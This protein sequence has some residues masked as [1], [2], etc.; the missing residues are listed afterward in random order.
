[1]AEIGVMPV[2][3]DRK[4]LPAT[5]AAA[6]DTVGM[7]AYSKLGTAA[8]AREQVQVLE[9]VPGQVPGQVLEQVPGQ[10]VHRTG[11]KR[12]LCFQLYSET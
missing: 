7:P 4:H 5:L 6:A 12:D 10:A 2:P 9:Q 1:A 8:R 11:S 3:A